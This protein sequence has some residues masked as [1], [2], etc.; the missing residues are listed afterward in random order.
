M[1]KEEDLDCALNI[2][3]NFLLNINV[4]QNAFIYLGEERVTRKDFF[5]SRRIN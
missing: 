4:V 2:R 1:S 5:L 3:I